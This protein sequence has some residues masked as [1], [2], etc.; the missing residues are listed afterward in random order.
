MGTF[1]VEPADLRAL[2]AQIAELAS[3]LD[4]ASRVRHQH[5]GIAGSARVDGALTGFFAH[6]SDG[7]AKLNRELEDISKRLAAAAT[8]YDESDAAVLKATAASMR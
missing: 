5:D 2:S 7:M 1:T 4:T 6:W 3:Q 8:A